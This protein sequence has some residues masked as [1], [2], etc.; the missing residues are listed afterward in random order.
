MSN[1]PNDVQM[2]VDIAV[3]S[4]QTKRVGKQLHSIEEKL[5]EFSER[6]AVIETSMDHST[7]T[8]DRWMGWA[9]A[10]AML[11]VELIIRFLHV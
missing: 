7:K 6:I 4:D 1:S 9:A 11:G 10:A 5:D 8:N 2:Q 3:L